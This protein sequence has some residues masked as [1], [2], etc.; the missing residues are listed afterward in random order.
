MQN[1]RQLAGA[2]AFIL[3]YFVVSRYVIDKE[4]ELLWAISFIFLIVVFSVLLNVYLVAERKR[5]SRFLKSLKQHIVPLRTSLYG[6]QFSPPEDIHT[7][8]GPDVQK[9]C[10]FIL[11]QIADAFT[12]I[13]GSPC[14]VSIK[15]ITPND[16]TCVRTL[17]RDPLSY[18]NRSI[19]DGV[20]YSI[21]DNTAF[22]YIQRKF[23]F[24]D[25][26]PYFFSNSLPFEKHYNNHSTS[27]YARRQ[28]KWAQFCNNRWHFS[29]MRYLTWPLPYKSTIVAP[30]C[31]CIPFQRTQDNLIGFLC[32]DSPNLRAFKE[33]GDADLLIYVAADLYP[34]LKVR[35]SSITP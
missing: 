29:P 15:I 11:A 34:L 20:D 4:P 31:P 24:T 8:R 6:H 1:I 18:V 33:P 9:M 22:D 5:T 10:K 14:A 28:W 27:I 25:K 30:V 2:F 17:Y 7:P 19:T 16:K 32:V 23:P 21:T 12:Q 13:T 26:V 3:T 35:A